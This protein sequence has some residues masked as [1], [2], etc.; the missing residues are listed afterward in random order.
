MIVAA[1]RSHDAPRES[2]LTHADDWNRM[3]EQYVNIARTPTKGRDGGV[4][5]FL[6][7]GRG[8]CEL[9]KRR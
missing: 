9:E 3:A 6:S 8:M 5:C 1:V 4:A 7:G 2:P